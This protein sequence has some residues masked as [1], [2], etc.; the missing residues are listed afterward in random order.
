MYL[1]NWNTLLSKTILFFT[2]ERGRRQA[3]SWPSLGNENN[4]KGSTWVKR[5][6]LQNLNKNQT[7][8]QNLIEINSLGSSSIFRTANAI[9]VTPFVPYKLGSHISVWYCLYTP[10]KK[11]RPKFWLQQQ[12]SSCCILSSYH[13]MHILHKRMLEKV[14]E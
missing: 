9:K 13:K 2:Q 6:R 5:E 4:I 10:L 12:Q 14:E 11:I 1:T 8:I 3:Q 7:Q